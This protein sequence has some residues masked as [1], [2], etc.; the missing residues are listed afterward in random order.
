MSRGRITAESGIEPTPP[1]SGVSVGL[2]NPTPLNWARYENSQQLRQMLGRK[3]TPEERS[4]A[5][6]VRRQLATEAGQPFQGINPEN[7]P[8]QYGP[9]GLPGGRNTGKMTYLDWPAT[10]TNAQQDTV[11]DTQYELTRR[12]GHAPTPQ[13][14]Q[15]YHR[16]QSANSRVEGLEFDPDTG[17]TTDW[18]AHPIHPN[19]NIRNP[20]L[21]TY[22]DPESFSSD[23][24][25][26]QY[27]QLNI[28][29]RVPERYNRTLPPDKQMSQDQLDAIRR[30]YYTRYPDLVPVEG[31]PGYNQWKKQ[32]LRG[33]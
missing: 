19:A 2:N 4:A 5:M 28:D 6:Q 26:A 30:A 27:E 23:I 15:A 14:L 22:A 32:V 31:Q 9:W 29:P 12:L 25:A 3:P 24:N 18:G 10:M 7:Y 1:G 17:T 16:R 20:R 13:E 11:F 21:T 8:P 33:K